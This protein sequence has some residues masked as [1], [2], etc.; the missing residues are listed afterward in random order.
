MQPFA[1][2][3]DRVDDDCPRLL[4]NLE[5][6]GEM[7][8]YE[9]DGSSG[10]LFGRYREEGFDFNGSTRGGKAMAR[11]ARWLGKADEGVKELAKALGWEVR[12]HSTHMHT[13]ARADRLFLV[14]CSKSC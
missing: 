5:S 6:V 4:I 7:D 11:D 1:S 9:D 8:E 10:S 13:M 3:V 2:L 12:G 14:C